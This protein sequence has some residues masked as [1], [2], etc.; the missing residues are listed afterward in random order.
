[1]LAK[2]LYNKKFSSEIFI[3]LSVYYQNYF[4]GGV[5]DRK[6]GHAGSC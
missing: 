1:M 2:Y 3:I 6:R 4:G 5:H